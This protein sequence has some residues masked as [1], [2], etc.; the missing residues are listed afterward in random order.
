[1]SSI[2][3]PIMRLRILLDSLKT[4]IEIINLVLES[5]TLRALY[6]RL[7]QIEDLLCREG[8]KSKRDLSKAWN[9]LVDIQ[10]EIH[11]FADLNVVIEAIGYC[12]THRSTAILSE[13]LRKKIDDPEVHSKYI[14][15]CMFGRDVDRMLNISV[16][17]EEPYELQI[18]PIR[19]K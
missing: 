4:E 16:D 7:I 5:A 10:F 12:K 19:R 6:Q 15:V 14:S 2:I 8:D 13:C 18:H 11:D 1:M 3:I 9:E 17:S